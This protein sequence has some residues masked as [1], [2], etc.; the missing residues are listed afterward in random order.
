MLWNG[1]E[2]GKTK[3]RRLSRQPSPVQI[4]IDQKQLDHVEYFNYLGSKIRN[5]A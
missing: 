2:Y 3:V 1:N 5:D 4:K